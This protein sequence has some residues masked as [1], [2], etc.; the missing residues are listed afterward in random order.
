[1]SWDQI[2]E[3]GS[4]LLTYQDFVEAGDANREAF[5]LEAIRRP[6][7]FTIVKAGASSPTFTRSTS[8]VSRA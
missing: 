1:M 4:R 2:K 8:F 6:S 7:S 3:D 5:V